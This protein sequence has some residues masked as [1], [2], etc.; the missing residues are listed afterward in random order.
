MKI[1]MRYCASVMALLVISTLN[2]C[3]SNVF[4]Q[5][6]TAFTYQGQLHDNG[7]NAN[8][9]YTLIF[10][11]YD[12]A[13]GSNLIGGPIITTTTLVNGLFTVN[14]DFGANAFN[15]STRYLDIA[16][17]SGSDTEELSPRV[18]VLPSPYAL[19]AA[20][21]AEVTNGAIMNAQLAVNAVATT[22]IQ[23]GAITATQIANNTITSAQLATNSVYADDIASGQVVKGLIPGDNIFLALLGNDVAEISALVPQVQIFTSSGTF[24]VPENATRIRVEAWGGGG[25]GGAGF[26]QLAQ[27]DQDGNL[28][29]PPIDNCGGGGGGGAFAVGTFDLSNGLTNGATYAVIV[30]QGGA[31]GSDGSDSSFGTLVTASAGRAGAGADANDNGHG[32]DGG[33]GGGILNNVLYIAGDYGD[34]GGFTGNGG[35]SPRGGEPAQGAGVTANNNLSQP[36]NGWF[37]GGGGGGGTGGT[38]GSG[39]TAG[40]NGANGMVIVYY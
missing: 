30:G 9:A 38:D 8:G 6:T 15:G 32:G 24:T 33:G 25:G 11:L 37:P 31:I 2:S 21:A 3:L 13:S 10:N 26:C 36:R 5:G 14:L 16:V 12:S 19:Y 1:S 22:N 34:S 18:Q 20:L 4:A 23:N 7:T 40:A 17:Q 35:A 29:Q 39:A 28:T 27:Y